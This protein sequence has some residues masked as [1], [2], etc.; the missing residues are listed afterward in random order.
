MCV[1]PGDDAFAKEWAY[2]MEMQLK[3]CNAPVQVSQLN[4]IDISRTNE[5]H[6]DVM[7]RMERENPLPV[8]G[9]SSQPFRVTTLLLGRPLSDR[10]LVL[11]ETGEVGIIW[12]CLL[13]VQ[14][15]NSPFF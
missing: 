11:A 4:I 10:L 6:A 3:K 5:S 13:Q 8:T 9:N 2:E 7:K 12:Y 14:N 15:C 1:I